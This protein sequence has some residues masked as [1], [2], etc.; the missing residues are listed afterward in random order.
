MAF[1][2]PHIDSRR[3]YS[4]PF[5]YK[6]KSA[7]AGGAR[8]VVSSYTAVALAF[9]RQYPLS[10]MRHASPRKIGQENAALIMLVRNSE[11][12]EALTSMRMMEDRFNKKFRYPW[13]F[14]NDDDFTEEFINYTSGMAS[15][16]T[17][18]GK[19]GIEQ[20]SMPQHIDQEEVE[21][22][23]EEMVRKNVIYAGSMSYRHMCRY[24]S[25]FFYRHP[26]VA[27]YDWYWRVEPGVEYF[28]DL[29]YDP[30]TYMRENNKTYGFVMSMYEYRVTIE[31]LWDST[32]EFLEDHPQFIAANNALDFFV[33]NH[34]PSA[35]GDTTISGNYNLCH[36]WSN[37]EIADLRFWRSE[38]YQSYFDYLDKLGGFFYERW[39]DAPIH[40]LAAGLFLPKS[41]IHHFGDIGYRHPP[42][43][44]CPQV[45]SMHQS[46]QCLCSRH[47]HFDDDGYSC[48]PRWWKVAGKSPGADVKPPEI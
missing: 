36:F 15:G 27:P 6:D 4:P 44:R 28:C 8:A 38:A 37:F 19:I 45:E 2:L 11:L 32:R 5:S 14:L 23:M 30:F 10:R 35:E 26:L 47:E 34:S 22:R 25:G 12:H 46:G 41:K 21:R 1:S 20:W 43:A 9:L 40:S 13:I 18:Y 16:D 31:T 24:N 3:P 17:K 42:Y 39:G 48:L 29:N 33:D 7:T